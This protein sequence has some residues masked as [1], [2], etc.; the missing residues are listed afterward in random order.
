MAMLAFFFLYNDQ[1]VII[2]SRLVSSGVRIVCLNGESGRDC[3]E[4]NAH[5]Y[6][7]SAKRKTPSIPAAP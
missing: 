1:F 6:D 7:L 2:P 4:P 5:K 3:T